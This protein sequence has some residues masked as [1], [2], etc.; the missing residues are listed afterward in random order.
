MAYVL[1]A[2]A[3]VAIDRDERAIH[4]LLGSAKARRT[5]CAVVAQVWREGAK[6]ARLALALKGVEVVPLDGAADRR[7]GELL[8]DSG[9]SDVVDGHVALLTRSGDHVITSDPRDLARLL[10]VRGVRADVHRI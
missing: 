7:I 9:T 1:D 4:D 2:G 10:D 6:Q 5:S 3:L 8:R